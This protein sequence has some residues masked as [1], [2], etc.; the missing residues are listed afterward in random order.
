NDTTRV[1]LDA[2]LAFDQCAAVAVEA[3]EVPANML[4]ILDSSGSMNCVAPNGDTAEAKLCKTDPR[5][6]GDGPSKWQI[7]HEALTAALT[8]LVGRNNVNVAVAAFPLPGSR[9]DVAVE[10][11]LTLSPLD[12]AHLNDI[13]ARLSAVRP[14]GETPV[15]GATIISYAALTT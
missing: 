13:S 14:D 5:K 7:T 9:C 11:D 8:P 12:E 1:A 10:P 2:G 15:A 4:F 3:T 6:R